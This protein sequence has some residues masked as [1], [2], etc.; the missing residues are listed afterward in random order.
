MAKAR[1]KDPLIPEIPRPHLTDEEAIEIFYGKK[2]ASPPGHAQAPSP[3]P[4]NAHPHPDTTHPFSAHEIPSTE[5][6]MR[7][8]ID[9]V[10]VVDDDHQST[11]PGTGHDKP[12]TGHDELSTGQ[13]MHDTGQ[14]VLTTR[15]DELSTA[16]S[17]RRTADAEPRTRPP[18]PV[19]GQS[20]RRTAGTMT[21]VVEKTYIAT[22]TG[23]GQDLLGTGPPV[24]STGHD[25]PR[26]GSPVPST[27]PED[28]RSGQTMPSTE[29][30]ALNTGQSTDTM[31]DHSHLTDAEYRHALYIAGQLSEKTKRT[32]AY[33]NSIRN[34]AHPHYT[35]RVGQATIASRI[36]AS[37]SGV[38]KRII[39]TLERA[40]LLIK[41]DPRINGTIYQLT[42]ADAFIRAIVEDLRP[43]T[44]PLPISAPHLAAYLPEDPALPEWLDASV[45]P[46]NAEMYQQLLQ[47]TG[48]EESAHETLQILL[49]NKSHGE[50]KSR[51]RDH[52]RVLKAFLSNPTM[53]IW[54]ND[55]GYDTL[56]VRRARIERDQATAQKTLMEEAFKVQQEERMLRFQTQL[57]EAQWT[58][59]RSEAK[60]IVDSAPKAE[61]EFMS[62]RTRLMLYKTRED[63]LLDEWLERTTYG[64]TVP[65]N[66]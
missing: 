50:N 14:P 42:Q 21:V 60:R 1:R 19:T 53:A 9:N 13:V 66:L 56:A 6:A 4:F 44:L 12:R 23:R 57:T 43:A 17:V 8:N 27:G 20:V 36:S 59:I 38:Q 63:E 37:S 32:L 30:P 10:N 16:Q 48:S 39:P 11:T 51:V 18:V 22:T 65:D 25:V 3:A 62:S 34:P 58:W 7:T 15:H 40:G 29:Q 41:A 26:T 61:Q 46:I 54:P 28:L 47:R 45:W 35:L 24:P 55:E 31:S 33:L 49:Y 52:M 5:H 64:E 2:P